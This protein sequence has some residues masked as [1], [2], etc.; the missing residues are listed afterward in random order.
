MRPKDQS[1]FAFAGL[2]EHWEDQEAG[3]KI[4]SCTIVT[5]RVNEAVAAA[6]GTGFRSALPPANLTYLFGP[7]RPKM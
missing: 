5:T 6:S 4:D 7:K 1:M 3:Q 2:W